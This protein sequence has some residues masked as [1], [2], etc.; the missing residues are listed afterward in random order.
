M[1]PIKERQFWKTFEGEIPFK[2]LIYDYIWFGLG[3]KGIEARFTFSDSKLIPYQTLI[4][5]LIHKY[6]NGR[7]VDKEMVLQGL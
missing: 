3:E 6:I 2:S 4:S 5:S 1:K 7:L